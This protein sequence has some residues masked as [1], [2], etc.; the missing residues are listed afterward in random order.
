MVIHNDIHVAWALKHNGT[1]T[2]TDKEI[3]SEFIA[4]YMIHS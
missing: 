1:H 2:Q 4:G 3:L